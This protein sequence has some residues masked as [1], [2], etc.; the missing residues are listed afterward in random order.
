MLLHFISFSN[1]WS[2]NHRIVQAANQSYFMVESDNTIRALPDTYTAL[3]LFKAINATKCAGCDIIP[4]MNDKEF[5]NFAISSR[6]NPT[7]QIQGWESPDEA[8]R[9]YAQEAEYLEYPW[10]WKK[11]LFFCCMMNPSIVKWHGKFLLV[12]RIDYAF[13][14]TRLSWLKDDLSGLDKEMVHLGIPSGF[15]LYPDGNQED[16]RAYVLRNN[17]LLILYGKTYI[18]HS[19]MTYTLGTYLEAEKRVYFSPPVQ[20]QHNNFSWAFNKNWL[21]FYSSDKS[22]NNLYFLQ[23]VNPPTV[24]IENKPWEYTMIGE[25][26]FSYVTQVYGIDITKNESLI[27]KKTN[28]PWKSIKYGTPRGGSPPILVKDGLLTFFHTVVA[29]QKSQ[30]WRHTYLMGAIL[31]NSKPPFNILKSSRVPIFKYGNFYCDAWLFKTMDYVMFPSGALLSE[32]EKTIWLTFGYQ[33]GSGYLATLDTEGLLESL[34]DFTESDDQFGFNVTDG[35][36]LNLGVNIVEDPYPIKERRA[37]KKRRN[38]RRE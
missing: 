4:V 21:P 11:S 10:W 36:G 1:S 18:S 22:D 30:A 35:W 31:Y 14:L 20:L 23:F 27:H 34:H 7:L 33:D 9:V 5:S 26:R 6:Y 24:V 29:V 2:I 32:D 19:F 37:K 28:I 16:A 12:Y 13:K 15:T 38:L 17:S 8:L 25:E 3:R